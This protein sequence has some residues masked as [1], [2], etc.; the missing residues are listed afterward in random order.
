MEHLDPTVVD[1]WDTEASYTVY[2]H[3][4][5]SESQVL[6]VRNEHEAQERAWPGRDCSGLGSWMLAQIGEETPRSDPTGE[7][8]PMSEHPPHRT[9]DG[10]DNGGRDGGRA[11]RALD[12][13]GL[14]PAPVGDPPNSRRVSTRICR[15][16]RRADP[17]GRSEM[18]WAWGQF[19][20]HELDRIP[21]G[22][23]LIEVVVPDDDPRVEMRGTTITVARSERDGDGL[24]NRHTA[25][26]DASN[27]YGTSEGQA[28]ELR[29]G[30]RLACQEGP[31]G[32]ALLPPAPGPS[33]RPA[34]FVAGDPR[35]NENTVLIA[36]HTLWLREHNRLCDVLEADYGYRGDDLF[37]QARLLVGAQ[38]QVITYREFLPALLGPGALPPW[39]GYR[40]EVDPGI[41]SLFATAA[42]RVGHTMVGDD[43]RLG[44]EARD[45]P[46]RDAFFQPALIHNAGIEPFLYGLARR[47]ME[48][49]DPVVVD[50]LGDTLFPDPEAP[51][52]GPQIRDLAVLNIER[53][54]DHGL[55]PYNTVRH[56][57][58]L[59]PVHDFVQL[60]AD[61]QRAQAL[62]ELYGEPNQCDLWV[63]LLAEDPRPPRRLGALLTK[64]LVDQFTRIRDGDFYWWQHHPG[65]PEDQRQW[66][67]RRLLHDVIR[68][69]TITDEVLE[70][71]PLDLFTAS[72]HP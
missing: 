34:D 23:D 69:N 37:D 4:R 19:L 33:G 30:A 52:P 17:W 65:L 20:D 38:M 42:Y 6:V 39:T 71:L 51:R 56:H 12:E 64:I 3:R 40:A 2:F 32:G 31:G 54:R 67:S 44:P 62:T 22:S 50:T 13:L 47:P 26:V 25:Y 63:A 59:D 9:Y 18:V 48:A 55:P 27:V 14:S 36:M 15:G 5:G 53:G 66:V 70:G 11:G 46:L 58:G 45:L 28:D 57:F 43:L 24:P 49:V 29:D 60:T 61:G 35:V 1:G 8:S 68:D 7:E 41:S 72:P 10:T 16:P 21:S